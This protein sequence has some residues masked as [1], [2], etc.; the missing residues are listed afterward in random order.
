MSYDFTQFKNKTKEAEG[1]LQRELATIRAGR[2]TPAIL[3]H[4]V[5]ESYGSK[6]PI[7]NVGSISIDDARTL[8]ITPWDASQVKNIESAISAANLGV[9][10]SPAEGGVRII[11]PELTGEKRR[12]LAKVV[13]DKLEESKI[14][15]KTEREKTWNDIQNKERAKQISEDDKFRY[16]DDLQ[17]LVDDAHRALESLAKKKESEIMS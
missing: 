9:S 3:D 1:W 16:K 5:V 14:R 8:R 11:F 2:A 6:M 13:H 7:K 15:V 12:A 4:I 17:K 10:S